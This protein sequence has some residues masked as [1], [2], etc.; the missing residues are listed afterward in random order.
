MYSIVFDFIN[1]DLFGGVESA[2]VPILTDTTM[3]LIYVALVYMLIW[4]FNVASRVL[5]L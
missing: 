3:I 2:L 5:K 4:V 1:Q